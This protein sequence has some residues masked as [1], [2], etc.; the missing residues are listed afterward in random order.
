MGTSKFTFSQSRW[1]LGPDNQSPI[2]GIGRRDWEETADTLLEALRPYAS[3]NGA[4]YQLPGFPS[5]QG[6]QSSALEGFSR[7]FLLA[8][9]RIRGASGRDMD[10]LINRYGNGLCAGVRLGGWGIHRDFSQSIVEAASIAMALYETRPWIW[11]QFDSTD[12]QA[13]SIWLGGINNR[14]VPANNWLLFQVIVNEFLRSVEMPHSIETIDQNLNVIDSMYSGDGW[15]SDGFG[16]NFDHYC[17]WA[18][19]FYTGMWS[20]MREAHDRNARTERYLERLGLFVDQY[21]H[22]FG[23][24]GAPI[25]IGRSLTY[26]WAACAPL[27]LAMRAGTSS[28]T[29]GTVRRIASGCLQYFLERGA[30]D[31]TTGLLTTGWHGP[32]PLAAQSYSGPASPYWAAKG[33]LG[34]SL[35]PSHSVWTDTETPAPIDEGDFVQVMPAPGWLVQGTRDDGVVR[36]YNHGSDH[37][38]WFEGTHTDPHYRKIG[39]STVTGPE[40]TE[41]TDTDSQI[42]FHAQNGTTGR[43]EHF[44][45]ARIGGP[46]ASSRFFPFEISGGQLISPGFLPGPLRRRGLTLPPGMQISRRPLRIRLVPIRPDFDVEL[47]VLSVAR[48]GVEVRMIRCVS[49]KPGHIEVGSFA[50]ADEHE[51]SRESDIVHAS[52]WRQDG[53]RSTIFPLTRPFKCVTLCRSGTNA[54]GPHSV[55]PLV[56]FEVPAGESLHVAVIV[57]GKRASL[58]EIC[59][60]TAEKTG[61]RSL[62]LTWSDRTIQEYGFRHGS[63][64]LEEG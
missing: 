42:V 31:Q 41:E 46:A 44:Y 2:T 28:V 20:L 47:D 4:E 5:S 33:F 38:P 53:M 19:V 27:W 35:D 57:L 23:G 32:H 37:F 15:Y 52:A 12:Q 25:H 9:Y 59:P 11:D 21:Q 22:L 49:P 64:E 55:I 14:R 54:F 63:W 40:L 18:M 10:G 48:L 62:K 24:D 61:E 34:L 50:M 39:Y 30:V 6:R 51:P 17:G 60:V 1:A 43:R 29:P 3:R 8:A 58:H 7:P 56:D 13:I 26:R 45:R 36:V 16:A